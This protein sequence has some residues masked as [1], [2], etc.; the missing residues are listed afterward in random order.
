[1]RWSRRVAAVVASA[2]LAFVAVPAVAQAAPISPRECSAE[3]YQGD[4]RLGPEVLPRTGSVGFQLF[5]YSRTGWHSQADFL[6]KFYDSTANSWRYPPQD[7]YVLKFDGT[8]LK[9][10]QTLVRGQRIDRYGSEYGA[11]LAPEGLPY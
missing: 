6:G 2:V 5:G 1:M 4:R 7:G 9:W 11:F 8:P 10:E 3:L